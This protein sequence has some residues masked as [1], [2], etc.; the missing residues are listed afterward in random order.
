MRPQWYQSLL[1]VIVANQ[2]AA[3]NCTVE[4]Q[5]IG[6][7]DV[8]LVAGVVDMLTAPQL[9]EAIAAAGRNRREA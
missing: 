1:E 5:R 6:E 3:S 2:P 4:Q 9:E 8:L 7:I